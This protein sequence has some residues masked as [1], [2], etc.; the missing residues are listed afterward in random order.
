MRLPSIRHTMPVVPPFLTAKTIP[1]AMA[2]GCV[3]VLTLFPGACATEEYY[4]AGL[5]DPH[6]A[7]ERVPGGRTVIPN[8]RIVQPMGRTVE[9]APHP[10]GLTLSPDGTTLVTANS[11]V[12]PFSISILRRLQDANPLVTQIPEGYAT[13]E[14]VLAAVFMGLAVAPDNTTLYVG[15]GQEGRVVRFDLDT[16]VRTGDIDLNTG[17]WADSYVGDLRLSADGRQL[18]AVDQTNF[19]LVIANTETMEVTHS[20]SVGR[21]PFGLALSPDGTRAYVANVGQFEYGIMGGVALDA[22]P[23]RLGTAFPPTDYAS[24]EATEGMVTDDGYV[25]PPL[26]DPNDERAHS[27]FTIDL[28]SEPPQVIAR[29]KTGY[30][31]GTEIEGIPAVG[32]SSPN[33]L[34]AT[35][36]VVV[37]TSGT[38]DL[39]SVLDP[40]TG[41]VQSEIPLRL[42]PRLGGLRGLIPFGVAVNPSGDRLYVAAAGINAVAVIDLD[43]REVLGYLPVGWFPS[44]LAVSP[45]GTHLYVANAKGWG[46]GPNGGPNFKMDG[47]G[48]YIGRLMNGSVSI[49]RLPPDDSLAYYTQRVIDQ[50]VRFTPASETVAARGTSHPIPAFPGAWASPI[51]HVVFVVKENRTYDEVFGALKGGNGEPSLARWGTDTTHYSSDRQ[52]SVRALAM[53]NHLALAE[54]FAIS[55]NFYVDADVSADGHRWLAGVYPNEWVEA[56]VAAAYGGGRRMKLQS[57]APGMLAFTGSSGAVYPEDYNEAGSIWDHF[58]RH[59]V[60][61]FNFGLG[62]EFSPAIETQAMKYTGIRL[63][64]NYPMPA[65]L[66]E[67]T[68][69]R[70]ATYNTAIPDQFRYQMF[71]EE[72]ETRWAPGTDALP[73]VLTVFLPQDHGAGDRPEAGYPFYASYMA[74]ND[75][76]LGRLVEYL[77][78]RPEWPEMA[79][80]VTQDDAQDGRDH[81]DAHRSVLM[82][83][84]PWTAPGTI[85]NTHASFGSIMKT[86]WHVLGT[87]YLNQYDATATDLSDL[88]IATPSN[89][90]PYRAI[91][92]DPALFDP[93]K[94]LDPLDADFDWS[95]LSSGPALD[96]V[97]VIMDRAASQDAKAKTQAEV[98]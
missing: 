48:S 97:D 82:V 60:S 42:D 39:I 88:F 37:V 38:N 27:V 28:T 53:P 16:G 95:A 98:E 94:A 45:D 67:R 24:P 19:R 49:I 2:M 21:Y 47:R 63:P 10:Y 4:T 3:L 92:P 44:K 72:L 25:V 15:G 91:L 46:A 30:L 18:Y 69:R 20:I 70:F 68:S 40:R 78:N 33:S 56:S 29:A 52:R 79:I 26:G 36:D 77:S 43:T 54:R 64:I 62:F 22:D 85:S 7:A 66:R 71:E 13:D 9:V 65:N 32:G 83:I 74:D 93:Q 6:L 86:M 17:S 23:P 11:G 14:G 89:V 90:A 57:T 84:S 96:D 59:E 80:I 5:P 8:G 55:D 1:Y 34:V 12:Q 61:Y 50:N 41:A 35:D 81:V 51:K 58:L 76:A 75:L 31:V 73:Q 87:P